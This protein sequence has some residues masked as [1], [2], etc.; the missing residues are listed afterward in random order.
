MPSKID[1]QGFLKAY[2]ADGALVGSG[3]EPTSD[4]A[5]LVLTK[6]T[7]SLKRIDEVGKV[8]EDTLD[9]EGN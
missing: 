5:K 8:K 3:G 9:T 6:Q 1:E 7:L 2:I 4:K